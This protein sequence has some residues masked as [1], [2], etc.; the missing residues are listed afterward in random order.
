MAQQCR[1]AVLRVLIPCFLLL[2][3]RE[4]VV[5]EAMEKVR[6]QM[7]ALEVEAL[8]GQ[9]G[10]E[11]HHLQALHREITAVQEAIAHQTMAVE[12]VEAHLQQ[13]GMERQLLLETGEMEPHLA[14]LEHP[15]PEVAVEVAGHI[16]VEPLELAGLVEAVMVELEAQ[17]TTAI[18]ALQTQ[19]AVAVVVLFK[20]M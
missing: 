20:P 16:K 10:L 12:V 14:L 3:L 9:V 5:R 13:A 4:V 6:D 2:P 7:V 1:M 17:T 11:I 18:R 19:V 8:V 15:S